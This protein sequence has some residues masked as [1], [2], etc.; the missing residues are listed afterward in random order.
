MNN[1]KNNSPGYAYIK[2]IERQK[3]KDGSLSLKYGFLP[4]KIFTKNLPK[5][6][7]V[8]SEK[9]AILPQL[10]LRND[11]ISVIGNMPVLPADSHNLHEKYLKQASCILSLLAHACWR[12]G[13]KKLM[14]T[15]NS[16]VDSWLPKS[17]SVPWVKVC[18]R[19]KRIGCFQNMN[20][21]MLNNFTFINPDFVNKQGIYKVEDVKVENIKI[22]YPSFN[23]EAERV[24]YGSIIEIHAYMPV[25]VESICEI[26]EIILIKPLRYVEEILE[27][28]DKIIK[29]VKSATRAFMKISPFKKSK[30]YCDTILWAKTIAIYNVPPKGADSGPLSGSAVPFIHILDA[31]IGRKNFDSEYGQFSKTIRAKYLDEK[32]KGFIHA[33]EKC[34]IIA[35][36]EGLKSENSQ[37]YDLLKDKFN[38]LV[39]QYAG[40]GGFLDKHISKVFNY[41]GVGTMVG[42]NQSTSLDERHVFKKTWAKVAEGL[43]IS[44]TERKRSDG[45]EKLP[46]ILI[47]SE[48]EIDNDYFNDQKYNLYEVAKHR[49][50]TD[51]WLIIDNGVYDVGP[52]LKNHPGGYEI[53]R[54][55]LGIDTSADFNMISQHA[56]PRVLKMLQKFRIGTVN[57]SKNDIKACAF[58]LGAE[59]V[60][61][62]QNAMHVQAKHDSDSMA[63]F[64]YFMQGY[65]NFVE[66]S[67]PE[68]IKSLTGQNTS[69]FNLLCQDL[70]ALMVDIT[71]ILADTK[72]ENTVE[73]LLKEAIQDSNQLFDELIEKC[74]S[75]SVN[76]F[77][78]QNQI[79]DKTKI[80]QKLLQD[81]LSQKINSYTKIK[82]D[83]MID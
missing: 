43:K 79:K 22:L 49:Y 52:Y 64:I 58:Y 40:E 44:A 59:Y 19:L 6:Y 24:F 55:H 83:L 7:N 9:I 30:T 15:R 39:D 48:N 71:C 63:K 82:K 42:R 11:A 67:I 12:F 73:I 4:E 29:S 13:I 46:N 10:A 53:I 5:P 36:I 1:N 32:T 28:L 77:E 69:G 37:K 35:F 25:I 45:V 20:D 62:I 38:D 54:I 57:D 56:I 66:E 50:D 23:N 60:I 72:V 17:I 78:K 8:W 21:L 47:C 18:D 14:T 34:N 68:L 76:V 3:Y 81:W 33:I 27:E 41:L 26:Q 70:K 61:R 2:S 80:I 74:L 16:D 51:G 75:I 31:F 65:S